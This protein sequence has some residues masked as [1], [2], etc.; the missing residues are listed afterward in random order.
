M[1]NRE[2]KISEA[3]EAA[4]K[5]P[6]LIFVKAIIGAMLGAIPAMLLWAALH[7][8][9]VILTSVCGFVMF[10]GEMIV[11]DRFMGKSGRLN[12]RAMLVICAVVAIPGIYLCERFVFACQLSD[13]LYTFGYLRSADLKE[14]FMNFERELVIFE[15]RGHFILSLALSYF[16]AVLGGI[17][18]VRKLKKQ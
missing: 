16:F 9:G 8:L 17:P 7:K 5:P 12:I 18:G 2:E 6:L 15:S 11:C 3:A 4:C 13:Y 10:L 14:C 1:D